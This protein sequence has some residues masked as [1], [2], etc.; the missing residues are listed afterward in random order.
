MAVEA[1]KIK[2]RLRALFPKANLSTKRLDEISAKLAK[3][4]EDGATDAQIDEVL[5]DYNDNGAMTFE[6]IA[7]ADDKIR[8]LEAKKPEPKTDEPKTDEPDPNEPA[9]FKLYREAQD[10]KFNKL[11]QQ[12]TQQTISQKFAAD[13]RLKGIPEFMFK[14][15]VPTK[16]EDY[17]AAIEGLIEVYKPFAE[18]NKLSAFGDDFPGSGDTDETPKTVKVK[19]IDADTAAKIVGV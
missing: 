9:W 12:N 7:K 8:T 15:Y 10:E 11:Q 19:E 4:P 2:A 6:E 14:G 16:D 13:K 1:A 5:N 17:E 3:K 18:K